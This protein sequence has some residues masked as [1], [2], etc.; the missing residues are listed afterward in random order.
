[1]MSLE[2]IAEYD[3]F[4]KE[5]ILKYGNCGSEKTSYM[6]KTICDEFINIIGI[7]VRN[8]IISDIKKAKYF[9]IIVDSTPNISHTDQLSLIIRYVDIAN[10]KTVERFL[11]F[12]TMLVIKRTKCLK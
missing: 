2:M 3:S 6:S 4:L 7:E 1:M 5:H 8:K 10:G 11:N 9:S 12:S